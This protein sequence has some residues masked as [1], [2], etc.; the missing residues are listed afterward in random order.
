MTK[1]MKIEYAC[2]PERLALLG[3]FDDVYTA[4]EE[5]LCLQDN[6]INQKLVYDENGKIKRWPSVMDIKKECKA[7]YKKILNRFF[8]N[9]IKVFTDDYNNLNVNDDSLKSCC[10]YY[11]EPDRKRMLTIRF[12]PI[13]LKE[14]SESLEIIAA[15]LLIQRRW[16]HQKKYFKLE[17][18]IDEINS[19]IFASASKAWKD[20]IVT[21]TGAWYQKP[22]PDLI[23][24]KTLNTIS[25]RLKEHTLIQDVS[26][27]PT[28]GN[29]DR[30]IK[31]PIHRCETCGK[32]FV[33]YE[34]YKLFVQEYGTLCFGKT[35][36]EGSGITFDGFAKESEL[37]RYGYNVI[38]GNL[39]ER[40][41][42]RIMELL[43]R[44][45]TMTYFEICRDI[46]NA[47]NIFDGRTK[48]FQA[49]EKW[50]RDLKYIGEFV[51][52]KDSW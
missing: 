29:N 15:E 23:V 17:E 45:K 10:F 3:A 35:P 46:E 47:I 49:C 12:R 42:H 18:V 22:L 41:R 26:L 5:I 16:R 6:Y 30:F 8:K 38:E 11:S 36:D 7:G 25:C 20:R 27:V 4:Y 44:T 9:N 51:S 24:F 21:S 28:L 52:E 1:S 37:H 50:K 33:G 34:T 14:F 40:E 32:L 39:S 43:I 19:R 2:T 31:L 13:N 48:Y